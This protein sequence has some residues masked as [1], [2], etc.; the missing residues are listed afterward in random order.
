MYLFDVCCF[1]IR[2]FNVMDDVGCIRSLT[3]YNLLHS[4]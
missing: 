4:F 3:V 1:G 2:T